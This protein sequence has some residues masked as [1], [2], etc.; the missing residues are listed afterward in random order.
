MFKDKYI[1]FYFMIV[2]VVIMVALVICLGI[3][4]CSSFIGLVFAQPNPCPQGKVPETDNN[5]DPVIDPAT[6][7]TKCISGPS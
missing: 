1:I 5:G 2:A 4:I 6:N 3:S 7:K